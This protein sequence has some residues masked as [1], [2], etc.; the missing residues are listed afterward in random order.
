MAHIEEQIMLGN[1][2]PKGRGKAITEEDRLQIIKL[3]EYGVP[4]QEIASVT[5]RGYS[6]VTRIVREH[7]HPKGPRAVK[8]TEPNPF[9]NQP[10]EKPV[11]ISNNYS[12]DFIKI[13]IKEG[14]TCGLNAGYEIVGKGFDAMQ[15]LELLEKTLFTEN[16]DYLDSKKKMLKLDISYISQVASI[17]WTDRYN[18]ELKRLDELQEEESNN[19]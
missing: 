3:E 4:M 8:I 12:E 14:I 7:K 1:L 2:E 10:Y 13:C 11:L 18:E 15:K 9:E 19:A 5:G 16:V 17:V 6:T